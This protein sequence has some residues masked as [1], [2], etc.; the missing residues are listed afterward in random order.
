[1]KRIATDI[2]VN[3]PQKKES[4]HLDISAIIDLVYPIF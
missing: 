2:T 4:K 3:P 1:M